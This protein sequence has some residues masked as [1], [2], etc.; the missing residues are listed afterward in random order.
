MKHHH[1]VGGIVLVLILVLA[2]FIVAQ[3]TLSV[4]SCIDSDEKKGDEDIHERGLVILELNDGSGEARE[5]SCLPPDQRMA[6]LGGDI[7]IGGVPNVGA[8]VFEMK[9]PDEGTEIVEEYITCP[10]GYICYRGAC[11]LASN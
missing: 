6:T 3:G 10:S 4:N 9:C 2:G 1:I 11:Q 8:G 7:G 5:D